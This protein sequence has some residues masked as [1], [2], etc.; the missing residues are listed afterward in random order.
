MPSTKTPPGIDVAR[1]QQLAGRSR[2]VRLR[3]TALVV[4][5]VLP[6][7][8]LVNLFGQRA[9]VQTA[10]TSA[11]SLEVKSPTRLRG[12]LTFTTKI[13]IT[14]HHDL[15]DGQLYLDR[16]WF[17]NMTFNGLSPQPA[18]QGAQGTWQIWDFGPMLSGV[19]FTVWISWQAN[20]TNVGHHA[21]VVELYDGNTEL[22]SA[23]H[24]VFIFP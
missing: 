6:V 21:Q 11:A 20:P 17:S 22:L 14:P 23:K 8:G 7:L 12:G 2:E 3:R 24:S 10:R 19:P 1:H 9:E 5:A 18:N 16:G 15:K 13:V 4:V